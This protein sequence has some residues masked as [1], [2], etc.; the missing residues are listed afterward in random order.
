MLLAAITLGLIGVGLVAFIIGSVLVSKYAF[1][2]STGQGLAV[3]LFPPYTFYFAFF[4]LEEE[5]KSW[6]VATWLFGLLVTVLLSV[7]FFPTIEH[8]ANGEWDELKIQNPG[9]GGAV[10][11]ESSE[12]DESEDDEENSTDSADEES[13]DEGSE[14]EASADEESA[15]EGSEDGDST[16]DEKKA[17][18]ESGGD[19]TEKAEQGDEEGGDEQAEK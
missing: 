3:L 14:D 11:A 17:D 16:N 19:G 10:A 8:V 4:K 12:D 2:I 1:R 5:D 18:D 13:G 6:P 15:E 9:P 7:V